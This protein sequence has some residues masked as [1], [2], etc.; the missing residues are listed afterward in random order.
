MG[1]HPHALQCSV[2]TGQG[3]FHQPGRIDLHGMADGK[4][5]ETGKLLDQGFERSRLRGDQS[6]RFRQGLA[7]PAG[8]ASSG[9]GLLDPVEAVPD[10]VGRELNRC[11]GVLDLVSQSPGDLLPGGEFLRPDQL[12]Q[13][14]QDH[15]V[16]DAVLERQVGGG[17]GDG[18]WRL[19]LAA[20]EIDPAPIGAEQA[21]PFFHVLKIGVDIRLQNTAQ[22]PVQDLLRPRAE[23]FH[24]RLVDGADHIVSIDAHHAGGDILQDGLD[25]LPPFIQALVGLPQLGVGLLQ[26]PPALAN[27]VGHPVEGVHQDAQLVHR[28]LLHAVVQIPFG[29]LPHALGQGLQRNRDSSGHIGAQPDEND[30]HD[31]GGDRHDQQVVVFELLPAAHQLAVPRRRVLHFPNAEFDA[32][33]QCEAGHQAPHHRSVG[34]SGRNRG[35][36]PVDEPPQVQVGLR[37]DVIVLPAVQDMVQR[38][39]PRSILPIA[40]PESDLPVPIHQHQA[41]EPELGNAAAQCGIEREAGPIDPAAEGAGR[42]HAHGLLLFVI[43]RGNDFR[44]FQ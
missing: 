40:L 16:L 27:L 4:P 42:N 7:K 39:V 1:F 41:V 34:T 26:P 17:G 21:H 10:A 6:R 24:G 29:K 18:Q 3:L 8:L 9:K 19:A 11:Q 13:V 36:S 30:H 37:G 33:G 23:H 31:Q 35:Q 32:V 28:L 5:G 25:I 22:G 2:V 44:R 12:R 20:L 38:K 43:V 14:V 15:Q